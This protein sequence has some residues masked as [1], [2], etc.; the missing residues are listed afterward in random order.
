MHAL[1]VVSHP[2]PGSLTHNVAAH[3]AEGVTMSGG[4]FEIADLA[5]EGFDPRFT[6]ADLAAHRRQ[7]PPLGGCHGRTGEDRPRRCA[8]A[9]L[10]RLLVVDAGATERVDRPRLRKRL[11]L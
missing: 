11:G 3:L 8:G 6:Q 9:R 5:A 1:I 10:S 2:E 4:S 7:A